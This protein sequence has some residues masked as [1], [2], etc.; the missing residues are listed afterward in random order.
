VKLLISAF[1]A[2]FPH[3]HAFVPVI[4]ML[5]RM[6]AAGGDPYCPEIN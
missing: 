3:A 1:R 4:V 2:V 6:A 5:A